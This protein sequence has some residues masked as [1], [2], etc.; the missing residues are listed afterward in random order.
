MPAERRACRAENRATR[1]GA[2]TCAAQVYIFTSYR[3]VLIR[4]GT[5][6]LHFMVA[7]RTEEW[8]AKDGHSNELQQ[9]TR[10]AGVARGMC[11]KKALQLDRFRP[12][13][14]QWLTDCD[15]LSCFQVTEATLASM[16][17]WRCY[18]AFSN[19]NPMCY[20]GGGRWIV[21]CYYT[22]LVREA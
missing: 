10:C 15:Q 18:E 1:K 16:M 17:V 8:T 14:V 13:I 22:M 21:A 19:F 20:C 11:D 3:R 5:G 7:P 9:L 2:I 12:N 4:E 6:F